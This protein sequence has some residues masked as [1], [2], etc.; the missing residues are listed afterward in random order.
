M[1]VLKSDAR[2]KTGLLK[3]ADGSFTM[4]GQK[5]LEV[6]LETRFPGSKEVDSCPEEFTLQGKQGELGPAPM[7]S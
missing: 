4:T 5:T 2:N 7:N 1:K 6:L 3:R